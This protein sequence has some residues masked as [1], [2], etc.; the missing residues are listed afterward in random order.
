MSTTLDFL[1]QQFPGL[2]GIQLDQVMSLMGGGSLQTARNKIALG[3]FPVKTVKFG[4]RRLVLLTDFAEYLDG[5]KQE[6]KEEETPKVTSAAAARKRGRRSNRE[7][8]R[9]R[10]AVAV[11]S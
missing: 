11:A 9:D 10:S 5:L 2:L 1:K 3:T 6:E 4:G 8:D 7:R